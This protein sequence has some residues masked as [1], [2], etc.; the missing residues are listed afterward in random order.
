VIATL[1]WELRRRKSAILWW[2]I[3]SV[4][5]AGLI[6]A[7]FPSIRDQANQLNAVINK[8]PAG[9]RELK[10]GTSG[11]VDMADPVGFLN[12]QLF[13]ATLPIM[14]I[15]LAVTRGSSVLGRDEQEHTLEL[16]LARPISRGKLLVS[17]AA[18]L[19]AEFV[20]VGGFT[21]LAIVVIAPFVDIHITTTHLALATLY[22]ALFSFSF[23]FIAFALQAASSLTKRAAT[24]IAV[25][26]GFG[27]YIIQSMSGLTDWLTT[28]AKFFPYH[29]FAPDKIMRGEITTGLNI[30]LIGVFIVLSI[31]A[32]IGF[33]RRDIS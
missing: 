33:R 20:I 21:L 22:T 17:K 1:L 19:L 14:W 24:A 16:L 4:A 29:Y 28:P 10:A 9:L 6:I 5:M 26:L 25:L 32:F 27:G 15:I 11:S 8:L 31:V 7:L 30:Y 13:Y 23:G 3:G 12:S 18:S 2:T